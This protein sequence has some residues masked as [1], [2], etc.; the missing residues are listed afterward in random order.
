MYIHSYH[1]PVP[2]SLPQG[3]MHSLKPDTADVHA[4]GRGWW[5]GRPAGRGRRDERYSERPRV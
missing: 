5:T 1:M 2:S 4:R 3:C